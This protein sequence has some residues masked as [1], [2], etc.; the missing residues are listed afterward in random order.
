MTSIDTSD[1]LQNVTEYCIKVHQICPVAMETSKSA[2]VW[3]KVSIGNAHNV[4][5]D[6]KVEWRG[7]SL[8]P[9][10]YVSICS[11]DLSN[12]HLPDV[13]CYLSRT[14]RVWWWP[15]SCRPLV[16]SLRFSFGASTR[17][18]AESDRSASSFSTRE[19]TRPAIAV[20]VSIAMEQLEKDQH[21]DTVSDSD[22]SGQFWSSRL[23]WVFL[24]TKI[25]A[26]F[27]SSS[28][29]SRKLNYLFDYLKCCIN[30]KTLWTRLRLIWHFVPPCNSFTC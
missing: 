19:T 12:G 29:F 15:S 16:M 25:T 3:R 4:C 2:M 11:V 1:R 17:N 20:R 30:A 28:E 9:T 7:V 8:A 22:M 6:F 26:F 21:R 23:L 27:F 14:R 5:R 10:S 24:L 13:S 18:C